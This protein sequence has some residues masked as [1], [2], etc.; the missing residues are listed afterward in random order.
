MSV[1]RRA[2]LRFAALAPFAGM[3]NLAAAV[4]SP[5]TRGLLVLVELKGGNDG[6][7]TVIPFA[8]PLY[9]RLRPRLAIARDQVLQLDEHA[10]LHPSLAKVLPIWEERRLAI[11]Q[12][13][14]YPK[15][16]L[17]HFRS[18]EIWDTASRSDEYL[19]A[20]WLARA[21]AASPSPAQFA[22]DGVVVGP[23]AMGPLAGSTGR[24]VALASPEQFLRN[25]R[26]ARGDGEARNEA[27]A[28]ILRVERDV[29]ATAERLNAGRKFDTPFPQGAFGSAVQTAA[30]LAANESAIAVVRLSLGGFDTHANQPQV[31]G[32]LLRQLAEGLASPRGAAEIDRGSPPGRDLRGIRPARARTRARERTT[33]RRASTWCS[34]AR[35]R[36]GSTVP[37]PRSTASMPRATC[38]SPSISAATTRRSSSVGGESAPARSSAALSRRSIGSE[39]LSIMGA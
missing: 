6:L 32:N 1:D 35:S 23:N 11:I 15:P 22:A 8:D 38:R 28:H 24:A 13:I 33:A 20:G 30:Q 26:L 37:R 25:A 34:G 14:G 19:D 31:H 3:A 2:F 27:L 39:V 4:A 36:E 29:L 17:S 9:A 7:N 16:N 12:G 21:F 18:I 5:A 10:G